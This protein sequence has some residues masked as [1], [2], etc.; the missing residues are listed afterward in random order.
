MH[1]NKIM[2]RVTLA[3]YFAIILLNGA[4]S[5]VEP[6]PDPPQPT[7]PNKPQSVTADWL[8]YANDIRPPIFYYDRQFL[9]RSLIFHDGIPDEAGLERGI[10]AIRIIKEKFAKDMASDLIVEFLNL[11]VDDPIRNRVVFCLSEIS[12]KDPQ[13]TRSLNGICENTWAIGKD[14]RRLLVQSEGREINLSIS[15]PPPLGQIKVTT[16]E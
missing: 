16:H 10:P 13:L 9:I 7:L 6:P 14:L 8:R 1:N 4:A 2:M 15:D 11:Q 3:L 5:A 12:Q